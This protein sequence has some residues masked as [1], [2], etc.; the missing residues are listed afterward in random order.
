MKGYEARFSGIQ[1][2]FGTAGQRRFHDSHV[3]VIGLGGVGSW[4][5]EALARSG[6]GSI[7][8][9]DMDE[10]CISNTNRQLHALRGETGQPKVEVMSRRLLAINPDAQLHPVQQF[11]T[12]T[13]ANGLLATPY[14]WV[15]DAIDRP[16]QKALL[17]AACRDRRIPVVTSGGAGGRRD[18]TR[19]RCAD[20]ADATHDPLLQQ[21]RRALRRDHGFPHG[22]TP[23]GI[24]AVFSTERP[25][26]PADDGTV[27]ENRPVSPDLRLDC[28]SGLGTA[29]FVTGAFG[30]AVAAVVIRR[31]AA[32]DRPS[33]SG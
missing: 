5:A 18:P 23:F 15:V 30:F 17:I 4:T 21:V 20:L 31:L 32:V 10:V 8:L 33:A 28:H 1:R 25:V 7:T 14:D 24:E 13:T 22:Q 3:C 16:D 27:C 19:V 2:L 26:F 6:V 9:V 12:R 11:F 29:A